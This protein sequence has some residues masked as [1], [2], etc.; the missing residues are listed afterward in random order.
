MTLCRQG[1]LLLLRRL[2]GGCPH[3]IVGAAWS[4]EEDQV[5][6][7]R[8]ITELGQKTVVKLELFKG[9]GRRWR[10]DTSRRLIAGQTTS[11]LGCES[12]ES[13]DDWTAECK[14]EEDSIRDSLE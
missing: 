9:Q 12:G 8:C 1:P 11:N 3:R 2:K 10:L 4:S 14:V 6:L 5:G 13:G 7:G